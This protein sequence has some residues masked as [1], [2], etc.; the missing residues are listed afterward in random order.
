MLGERGSH[1]YASLA[2]KARD[3][4]RNFQ[5]LVVTQKEL[6]ATGVNT[7]DLAAKLGTTQEDLNARIRF[8]IPMVRGF[9][10]ALD[11]AIT[12]KGQ[13][14]SK[15]LMNTLGTMLPKLQ[16][17]IGR[18]FQFSDK[19]TTKGLDNFTNMFQKFANIFD[20]STASGKMLK[21]TLHD[22]VDG[23]LA[24][25]GEVL[26][27]ARRGF[28]M[29]EIVWMTMVTKADPLFVALG[30]LNKELK[31]SGRHGLTFKEVL[32]GIGKAADFAVRSLT[33]FVSI[34]TKAMSLANQASESKNPAIRQAGKSIL[35]VADPFQLMG[36]AQGGVVTGVQDGLATVK[37]APGEGLASIG[38]GE[39]I[40]PANDT[41]A[42]KGGWS[43]TVMP[44]AVVVQGGSGQSKEEVTESGLALMFERIRLKQGLA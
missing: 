26:H 19:D 35:A 32:N 34:A 44:G 1:A 5:P 33:A 7:K 25:A 2:Q 17:N 29:L 9:G 10:N 41:A 27:G 43:V 3:A 40:V 18:L 4:Q 15:G 8:G 11:E 23:T 38:R 14:A 6:L 22:I 16:E 31:K 24:G 21:T 28:K 20:E 42:G 12:E 37:A 39:R 13:K 36:H 30:D